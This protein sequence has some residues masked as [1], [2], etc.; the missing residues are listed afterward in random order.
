MYLIIGASGMLG[1]SLL[2]QMTRFGSPEVYAPSHAE[3]PIENFS[4]VDEIVKRLK[5]K[6][7]IDCAAMKDVDGC[8]AEPTQAMWQNADMH[9]GLVWSARRSGAK[10]F[11]I[12]TDYVFDG[13]KG[14]AYSESDIPNPIQEYGKTKLRGEQIALENRGH[15]FRVQWLYGASKKNFVQTMLDALRRPPGGARIPVSSV[16]EGSPSSTDWVARV[17]L[18]AASKE[19]VTPGVYHVSHDDSCTRWEFATALAQ[20]LRKDPEDY[21][22]KIDHANFGVAKRPINIRL[23]NRKLCEALGF[24][25][26]GSWKSGLIDYVQEEFE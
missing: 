23:S 15:V 26:L 12:S 24:E 5:P 7:I 3:L 13:M 21:F 11:Y 14:K 25:R 16:Q 1:S 18:L 9:T 19:A 4:K 6:V 22:S 2:K 10:Y 8:E 17:I 20:Y